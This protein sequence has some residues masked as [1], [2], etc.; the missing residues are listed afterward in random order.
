MYWLWI[1]VV[2]RSWKSFEEIANKDLKKWR[3]VSA[4]E[5]KGPKL[6]TVRT[7]STSLPAVMWKVETV[8]NELND[9]TKENTRKQVESINW[10]ILTA[11]VVRWT[12]KGTIWFLF[13]Q[14]LEE[15]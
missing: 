9:L 2:G 5:E 3:N 13:K 15:I 7:I 14:N 6:R 8:P 12:K 11:Y 10:F 4:P 1:H